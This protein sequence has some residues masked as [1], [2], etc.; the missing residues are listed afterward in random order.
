MANMGIIYTILGVIL[1]IVINIVRPEANTI[2]YGGLAAGGLVILYGLFELVAGRR[3]TNDGVNEV[4]LNALARMSY[5]DTNIMDVEVETIR[6]IYSN[7]T[8]QEVSAA[9]VRVAA[10][11][12][13]W[14]SRPF[15]RYIGDV[16][17]NLSRED[18]ML[19]IDSLAEVSKSD[20]RVNP[21]EEKFFNDIAA[22]LKIDPTYLSKLLP[23]TPEDSGAA[24][25]AGD[26]GAADD[27]GDDG[28]ADD[29]GESNDGPPKA[30]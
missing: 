17:P 14:E 22:A 18:K 23:E 26:D 24:D 4:L 3:P 21:F 28:A 9:E 25:D 27:A 5:A 6:R 11:A 13:H 12:E 19:I 29:A 30:D 8:G 15:L 16:E 20:D 7:A 10:Q 2:Y 1:M